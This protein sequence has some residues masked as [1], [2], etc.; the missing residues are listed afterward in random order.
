MRIH[1]D[2][3]DA[4]GGYPDDRSHRDFRSDE[5][6]WTTSPEDS[7]V[8]VGEPGTRQYAVAG[9]LDYYDDEAYSGSGE[10]ALRRDL[11]FYDEFSDSVE[12]AR[13]NRGVDFGLLVLRLALGAV[14]VAHGAQKLFGAFGGPGLDGTADM[15]AEMG[16]GRTQVLAPLT[17]GTEFAAGILLGLGLFT[18]LAAA[19]LLGVMANAVVLGADSGFFLDGGGVEYPAVLGAA[20][21]ALL[22]TGPGRVAAD[23]GR[24]WFRRPV[25]SASIGLL[26]AVIASA[27]VLL[28]LR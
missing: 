20:A 16:F 15:L 12:A 11:D 27:A 22:F 8:G 9:E 10:G 23:K 19:G 17:G 7:T 2:R 25:L 28:G 13:W 6:G 5:G 26:I 18:P 1:D 21:L 24:A 14:F 4:A 3:P